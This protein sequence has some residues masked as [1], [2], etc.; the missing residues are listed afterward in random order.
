[1]NR[2]LVCILWLVLASRQAFAATADSGLQFLRMNISARGVALGGALSCVEDD[3]FGYYYNPAGRYSVK[4]PEIGVSDNIWFENINYQNYAYSQCPKFGVL[5][6]GVNLLSLGTIQ[7]YD[8]TGALINETYSPM[9][10]SVIMSYSNILKKTPYGI[11][12]K[13]LYSTID[14]VSASGLAFDFGVMQLVNDN[15]QIAVALQNIGPSM[16]YITK[17]VPLPVNLKIGGRYNYYISKYKSMLVAEFN[18]PN[19]SNYEFSIGNESRF[20]FNNIG[21]MP[22]IGL[23]I[24]PQITDFIGSFRIGA[25]V[26]YKQY[27]IDYSW[28]PYGVLG[29]SHIVTFK[30]KLGKQDSDS[31]GVEDTLDKCPDTPDK[32]K[33]T[34]DGCPVDS[35]K[36]GVPDY[37]DICTNT[38]PG[39]TVDEKGCPIGRMVPSITLSTEPPKIA[40]T[41]I[42]KKDTRKTYVLQVNTTTAVSTQKHG[43]EIN[44]ST[45]PV[46]ADE[47]NKVMFTV[48]D[49][50]GLPLS[51]VTIRIA[52]GGVDVYKL[53][54]DK[55]GVLIID[56]FVT[57]KYWVKAWK[58][59]YIAE[60][61]NVEINNLPSKIVFNLRVRT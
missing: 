56:N 2:Y 40:V 22:R 12:V 34:K 47:T 43:V 15:L 59:G 54:T 9:D 46:T 45:S 42:P 25:G 49:A 28:V 35:D 4:R 17:T 52:S 11:S 36:D 48:L 37:R 57:G 24:D 7:K 10:L 23:K 26:S 51:E 53:I 60:E 58:Q 33:V 5:T 18:V 38:P 1:M 20:E 41:V 27:T 55:N 31:D 6:A 39:T 21:F 8:N 50:K 32:V 30:M 44:V 19:N 13:Y 14:T 61:K 16:T 3:I 29:M